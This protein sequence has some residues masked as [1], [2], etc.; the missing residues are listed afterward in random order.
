MRTFIEQRVGYCEQ[1]AGTMAV[2]LRTLGIPSRVAVGFTPG[3]VDPVDPTLWTVSWANAHAWVEVKFGGEWIAFEPTPRS[4]GNVLVPSISDITPNQTAQA[5]T[6]TG[7]QGTPATPDET[8]NIFD[9]REALQNRANEVGTGTGTV[10]S[11]SASEVSRRLSDPI[12]V[13]TTV[14]LACAALLLLVLLG[15]RAGGA[16]TPVQRVLAVRDRIG[17]LGHGLGQ[18]APVWETD[19]EYLRRLAPGSRHG[20]ELASAVT[21]ARY[22]PAVSDD[23]AQ[24]AEHAG[25]ALTDELLDGRPAWRRALIRTRGDAVA[26]WQRVR[27]HQPRGRRRGR[28]STA[29]R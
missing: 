19:Q 1:F 7:S 5:P 4:D 18:P 13:S 6:V 15:R 9:E 2:M 25:A 24:R 3:T 22:A 16:T 12:V 28:R 14:L 17:R 27:S 20:D 10:L 26:G 8:F 29:G 21:T 23:V 11:T